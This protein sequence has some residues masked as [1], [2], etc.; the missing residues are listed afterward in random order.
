MGMARLLDQ[1]EVISTVCNCT[2]TVR[3]HAD[4]V[5]NRLIELQNRICFWH[6]GGC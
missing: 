6:E 4:L 3:L 2:C 5:A 1:G